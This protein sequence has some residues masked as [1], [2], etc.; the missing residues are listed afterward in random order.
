MKFAK[1]MSTV[2]GRTIRIVAGLVLIALGL[3]YQ[4]SL[5]VWGIIIAIIGLVPLIAGAANFCLLAP[6]FGGSFRA[7]KAG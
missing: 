3:Y 4:S 1:L 2:P 7:P 6:L 5:G